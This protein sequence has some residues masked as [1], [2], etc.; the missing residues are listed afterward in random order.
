MVNRDRTTR[1]V[2]AAFA[3][4]KKE[5]TVGYKGEVVK[6]DASAWTRLAKC[7][8]GVQRLRESEVSRVQWF[9]FGASMGTTVTN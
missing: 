7:L 3:A 2:L 5:V 9:R 4:H 1:E 8:I 6:K